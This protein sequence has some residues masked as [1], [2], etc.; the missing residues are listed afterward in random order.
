ML[1]FGR[2]PELFRSLLGRSEPT[3]RYAIAVLAALFFLG[4]LI[5]ELAQAF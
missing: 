5:F 2:A 3:L 4:W 1:M